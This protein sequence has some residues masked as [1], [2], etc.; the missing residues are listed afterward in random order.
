MTGEK[1][2]VK[3][4]S[5]ARIHWAAPAI[6]GFTG[7]TNLDHEEEARSQVDRDQAL[8]DDSENG[9][10]PG[11]LRATTTADRHDDR[12][13]AE[14]RSVGAAR[15][16]ARAVAARPERPGTDK[17]WIYSSPESARPFRI[18]PLIILQSLKR[19]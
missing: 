6:G 19:Y 12:P 4:F 1:G 9:G 13:E 2:F 5:P 10:R 11:R 16:R 7:R 15:P 3:H 17:R 8:G 18:T 14:D